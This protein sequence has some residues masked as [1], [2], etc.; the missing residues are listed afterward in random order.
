MKKYIDIDPTIVYND[1]IK[2]KEPKMKPTISTIIVVIVMIANVC[3][4]IVSSE[5]I[6]IALSASSDLNCDLF[7]L[8]FV[9]GK[10][11]SGIKWFYTNVL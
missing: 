5:S 10:L 2:R 6:D 8:G 4:E 1:N 9:T 7:Y 11:I 3:I